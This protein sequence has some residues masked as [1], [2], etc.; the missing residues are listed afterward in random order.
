MQKGEEIIEKLKSAKTSLKRRYGVTEVAL[1][2]SY[3][4]GEEQEDSYVELLI[5]FDKAPGI[6]FTDLEDELAVLLE[7]K[8]D[9]TLRKGIDNSYYKSIRKEL[10]YV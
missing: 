1:F 4:K 9:V 8:V 6:A 3:S 7:K 10:I 5:N 2:G